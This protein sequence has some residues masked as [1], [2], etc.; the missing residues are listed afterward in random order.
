M[1]AFQKGEKYNNNKNWYRVQLRLS[2]CAS[3]RCLLPVC[4]QTALSYPIKLVL[5]KGNFLLRLIFLTRQTYFDDKSRTNSTINYFF[6]WRNS[7]SCRSAVLF[8]RVLSATWFIECRM[9]G[10]YERYIKGCFQ[11]RLPSVWDF[12]NE[13][14]VQSDRKDLLTESA[15]ILGLLCDI[16]IWQLLKS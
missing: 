5:T 14:A 7:S 1:M 16:C 6:R 3:F 10:R 13:Q 12:V 8:N 15:R 9:E 11:D 4:L 2:V